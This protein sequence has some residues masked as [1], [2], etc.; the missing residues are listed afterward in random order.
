MQNEIINRV[1]ESSLITINLED[2][3]TPG[4]R[5]VYDLKGNLFQEIILKE[6]DFRA[7]VATHDWSQYQDKY[8]AIHCSTDAIVPGWAFMILASRIGPYAKKV[9]FGDLQALEQSLF[10]DALAAMDPTR[11]QDARIVV[12]GC[13]HLPISQF[14]YVEV[15][16]LLRPVVSSIM[17]GEPCSTV[18][19][20]KRKK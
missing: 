5:V 19:I 15:V 20:Y 12:K 4:E 1:A 2:Y 13:G 16:R 17:Y 18:P 10:Q 7:F 6:K 14:A 9:V 3:Y 8:V 11:F